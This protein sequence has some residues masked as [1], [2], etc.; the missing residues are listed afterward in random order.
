MRMSAHYTIN[1][2]GKFYQCGDDTRRNAI[3]Q[4]IDVGQ[5]QLSH[6]IFLGG[7]GDALLNQS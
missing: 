5:I 7:P 1:Y 2:K 4:E 6:F 3:L